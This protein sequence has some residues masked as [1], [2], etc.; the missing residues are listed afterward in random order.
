MNTI[1]KNIPNSLTIL[2]LWMG[3]ISV[4]IS[5]NGL[6][7]KWAFVFMVIGAIF[8]FFDGFA[9]RALK[10]YSEIGKEL[11]SLADLISFGLAPA[12]ILFRLICLSTNIQLAEYSNF[13]IY[14]ALPLFSLLIV[15][16]SALRLA[17][18]NIDVN[19]K[20]EF[21]GLPT[22]ANALFIGSL[23][24]IESTDYMYFLLRPESLIFISI[25]FSYLPVSK[26]PMFSFKISKF[27]FKE[28]KYQFV[29]LGFAIAFIILLKVK[30]LL[31]IMISYLVL[32]FIRFL[33]QK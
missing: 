24:F 16:F 18:F 29:L 32:N 31:F 11:D 15:A 12:A 21:I 7:L 22:P 30:A 33:A 1:R 4:F 14:M 2:N 27:N 3:S 28:N 20:T 26:L 19:Q 8:D 5:L 25:L 6:D 13:S 10:A 9:A 23:I 17:K